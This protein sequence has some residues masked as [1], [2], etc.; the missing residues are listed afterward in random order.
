MQKA[1]WLCFGADQ[2]PVVSRSWSRVRSVHNHSS[3]ILL[4]PSDRASKIRI[5]DAVTF[6][7]LHSLQPAKQI[8]LEHLCYFLSKY[9][10]NLY[11]CLSF[12][13]LPHL[14]PNLRTLFSPDKQQENHKPWSASCAF[15]LKAKMLKLSIHITC[16][17]LRYSQTTPELASEN[18]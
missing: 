18:Y 17:C 3:K 14:H 4:R 8:S 16:L 2:N 7:M 1:L 15:L 12:P 11:A 9:F 6:G 13:F 5:S 10:I